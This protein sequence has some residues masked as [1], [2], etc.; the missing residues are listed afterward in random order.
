MNYR[1]N[2]F[3]CVFLLATQ[4][5]SAQSPPASSPDPLAPT[6]DAKSAATIDRE[7]QESVAKYDGERKRLLSIEQQQE[8]DG[9]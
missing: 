9:P 6:L 8:N 2:L 4:L 1:G 5:L 7:W 3:F